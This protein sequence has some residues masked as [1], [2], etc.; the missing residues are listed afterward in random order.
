MAPATAVLNFKT[1]SCRISILCLLKISEKIF[2]DKY[3]ANPKNA[4]IFASLLREQSD[5]VNVAQLVRA[6]DCGPEGRGFKPHLS[7]QRGRKFRSRFFL[8]KTKYPAA[9]LMQ[10]GINYF[11]RAYPPDGTGKRRLLLC[12]TTPADRRAKTKAYGKIASACRH[13]QTG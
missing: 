11:L 7:P 13:G 1:N 5:M 4:L 8:C 2:R 3:L 9:R 12:R 10:Q 6:S